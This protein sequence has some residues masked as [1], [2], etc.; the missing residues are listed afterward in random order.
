MKKVSSFSV[1][2]RWRHGGFS[3]GL[4]RRLAR[5]VHQGRANIVLDYNTDSGKLNF[6]R[7]GEGDHW[8]ATMEVKMFRSKNRGAH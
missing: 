2:S 6:G 3:L 8:S 5:T 7:E 1:F 4:K